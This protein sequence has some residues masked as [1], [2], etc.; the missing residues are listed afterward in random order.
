MNS[1]ASTMA[2]EAIELLDAMDLLFSEARDALERR[3][4]LRVPFFRAVTLELEDAENSPEVCFAR[5]LSPS[6][7]GLLFSSTISRM[8]MSS[9]MCIPECRS[10]SVATCGSS[11]MP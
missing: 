3:F 5:D 10:Q 8:Q 11:V 2:N 1:A 9:K 4:E 6:G 7:T